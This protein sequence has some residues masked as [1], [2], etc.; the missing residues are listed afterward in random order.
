MAGVRFARNRVH[1]HW[2]DAIYFNES[3]G[4]TFPMTFPVYFSTWR[5]RP[6]A[7]LPSGGDD[8]GAEVYV[9]HLERQPVD[10]TLLQLGLALER[11]GLFLEPPR[12]STGSSPT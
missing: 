3:G 6:L 5:W 10:K 12:R 11:V 8:F 1:H 9:E 4:M 2:V 7:D